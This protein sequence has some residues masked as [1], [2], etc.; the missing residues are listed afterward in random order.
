MYFD[1]GVQDLDEEVEAE[2]KRDASF[3]QR[4]D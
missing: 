1:A 2:S 4:A 3:I